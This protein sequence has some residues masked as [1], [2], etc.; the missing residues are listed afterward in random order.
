MKNILSWDSSTD[1][2]PNQTHTSTL[3]LTLKEII[4]SN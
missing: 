2:T 4:F 3:A 1:I